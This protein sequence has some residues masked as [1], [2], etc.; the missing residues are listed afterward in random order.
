MSQLFS[1]FQITNLSNWSASD[2]WDAIIHEYKYKIF[3]PTAPPSPAAAD[4]NTACEQD[5]YNFLTMMAYRHWALSL[6]RLILF[7]PVIKTGK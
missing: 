6:L 7:L 3:Q 1:D 5:T 4:G 2:Q